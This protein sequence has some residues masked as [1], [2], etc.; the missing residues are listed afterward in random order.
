MNWLPS[1]PYI[2]VAGFLLALI[3]YSV[4]ENRTRPTTVVVNPCVVTFTGDTSQLLR[5]LAEAQAATDKLLASLS[6]L[7][8]RPVERPMTREEVQAF[9]ERRAPLRSGTTKATTPDCD[10]KF[11]TWERQSRL[12]A[13]AA[14]LSAVGRLTP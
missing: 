11:C 13:E 14:R 9:V 8:D 12:D 6:K 1:L 2:V 5:A 4:W 3:A 7:S 10:C